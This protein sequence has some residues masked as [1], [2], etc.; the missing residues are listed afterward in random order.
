MSIDPKKLNTQRLY[1][2]AAAIENEPQ[3]CFAKDQPGFDM[4]VWEDQVYS[5]GDWQHSVPCGT[6]RCIGG[7]ADKLF[8]G[9]DNELLA[10]FAV[11]DKTDVIAQL[12]EFDHLFYPDGFSDDEDPLNA[13][14]ATPKQAAACVRHFAETGSVDWERAMAPVIT[15]EDD[16][17]E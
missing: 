2:L 10:P 5:D 13:W 11:L 16:G 1:A 7:M 9:H 4:T 12:V 6:C 3:G 8:G 17:D 15:A 14:K